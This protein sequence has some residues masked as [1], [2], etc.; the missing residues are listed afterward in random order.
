[1]GLGLIT[2]VPLLVYLG[3]WVICL[4]TLGGRPLWGLYYLMPLLPYRTLREHFLNYPLGDN[5]LTI[6][7]VVVIIGGLIHGKKLPPSNLY[8]IWVVTAVFLYFSMWLGMLLGN[9]PAPLWLSNANFVTWK[10]YMLIPLI[11]VAACLVI[12]DRKTVNMVIIITGIAVLLVDRSALLESLS[13]SFA[14][15]DES[16]RDAGPLGYAGPNGLAAFLAQFSMFFWGF[17]QFIKNRKQKLLC[18]GLVATTL[19][20]TMYTFSRASY[21][22]LVLG[23]FLLGIL[24]D[25]KLVLIT[26]VFL[27]TWQTIVPV[28]VTERVTMTHD[29]NGQLEAS[30]EE[31]V[32][33]WDNAKAT[34][35]NNPVFGTGYATYQFGSHV[36]DL[37]DTHNWYVKVLVETGAVGLLIV[38]I[39]L[40]QVLALAFRLFRKAT[41][42]LYK[43]LGLGLFL[44]VCAC[45]IL[46]FFGDRWNYPE[47][48]G[49]LWVL[50]GAAVRA[51]QL[52]KEEPLTE[53]AAVDSTATANPYMAYR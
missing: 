53:T 26:A 29:S 22:A 31:R 30:A 25:R 35:L 39:M 3:F 36:D 51:T 7:V 13:R 28:A 43:G 6:L 37:K 1:V 47:I 33:L 21:I 23:T 40:Q 11:F 24:K 19:F 15:F 2:Y 45:I 5:V 44:A 52:A 16:K 34:M 38:L 32:K 4:I 48:I 50:A 17:G 14:H 9:A 8:K 42:P 18:Y 27:L 41:D 46:N 49:L 10:D 12:E 20:A